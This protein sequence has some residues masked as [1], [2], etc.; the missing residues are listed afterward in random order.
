NVC[1]NLPAGK[2]GMLLGFTGPIF[3]PQGACASGNHAIAA[4]ARMIRDGDCDFVLAGG[5]ETCLVP[6]IIQG[7]ANMLAT[8]KVGPKDRAFDDPAQ[9]SRPFSIDRKGFVLAEGAAVLVLAAE[10]AAA[11]LGLSPRAE[12]AGIG[13]NSDANHFTRPN[14]AT[15]IRAM[16]DAIDDAEI[17]AGDIGSVNAHGTSTPT[18]DATEVECLRQ[19]FGHGLVNTPVSANKSQ[20]GHSLGASAAI[21]AAL[22]IEAMREGIVLPT[23]NHRADPGFNDIDFVA[24]SSRRHSHEHVLSNSFGFGGTNCCIVFR[25]V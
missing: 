15:I 1:A 7:F 21:E 18:G 25:G 16:N 24:D 9:A 8:I 14:S 22:A 23:V 17:T 10:E 11:S 13:W 19:V 6:E 3:S 20:V 5:V 4:G 12:I 2:A